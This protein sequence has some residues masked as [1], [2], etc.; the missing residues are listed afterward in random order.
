MEDQEPLR[1]ALIESLTLL[2]YKVL[3]ADNGVDA[4]RLLEKV[5][6]DVSL[7]IS[8]VVMP[9]MGGVALLQNIRQRGWQIPM[10]LM[11]GHWQPD[12][13]IDHLRSQGLID[14]L[15]KPLWPDT[16][17]QSIALALDTRI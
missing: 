2:E 14:I 8:D 5:Q 9:Q 4:L 16:L 1:Q 11:S 12:M 13:D 10:L 15:A 7:I 6:E 17:A 3:V